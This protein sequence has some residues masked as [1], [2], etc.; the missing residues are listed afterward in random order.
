MMFLQIFL[1]CFC[2]GIGLTSPSQKRDRI[3][4]ITHMDK[5]FLKTFSKAQIAKVLLCIKARKLKNLNVRR[6]E[7]RRSRNACVL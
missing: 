1:T 3:P 4:N 5:V 6:K 2:P 7:E